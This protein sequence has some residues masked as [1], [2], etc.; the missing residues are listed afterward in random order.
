M[1]TWK[2]VVFILEGR[3]ICRSEQSERP[4]CCGPW[5]ADLGLREQS[6]GVG[7]RPHRAWSPARFPLLL[8]SGTATD[9][10]LPKPG[11]NGDAVWWCVL[12]VCAG[13]NRS[14]VFLGISKVHCDLRQERLVYSPAI[15]DQPPPPGV[16]T[17]RQSPRSEAPKAE[18]RVTWQEGL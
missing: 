18:V 10:W 7:V 17:G 13:V 8:K 11:H 3:E 15:S 4:I 14:F 12:S 9:F 5:G 2:H 1:E 6:M 16:Q